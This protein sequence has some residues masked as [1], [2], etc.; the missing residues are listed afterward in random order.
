[1]DQL[2]DRG[3]TVY[4]VVLALVIVTTVFTVLRVMSK[5]GIT[6]KATADDLVAVVAWALYIGLSV[7]ILVG[8]R[9]GLGAPDSG[10]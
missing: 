6:R 7:T 2:H 4:A 10:E 3:P 1:M 8:T 5:L 9:F